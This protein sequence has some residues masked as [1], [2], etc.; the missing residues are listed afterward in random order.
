MWLNTSCAAGNFAS[1]RPC[2]GSNIQLSQ[3][4]RIVEK[5]ALFADNVSELDTRT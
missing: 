4:P 3:K 5:S 1:T 2:K